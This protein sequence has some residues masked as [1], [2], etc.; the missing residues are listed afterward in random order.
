MQVRVT[1]SLY[2]QIS[3][4]KGMIFKW[5]DPNGTKLRTFFRKQGQKCHE[6]ISLTNFLCNK[7]SIA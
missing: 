3:K 5:T 6:I 4:Y 7:L 1:L 2:T